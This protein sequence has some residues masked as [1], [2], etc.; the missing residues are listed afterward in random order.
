[1]LEKLSASVPLVL[2]QVKA[3]PTLHIFEMKIGS[4]PFRLN[5]FS[6]EL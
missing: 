1:M 5:Y 3:K 6:V 2:G 4:M